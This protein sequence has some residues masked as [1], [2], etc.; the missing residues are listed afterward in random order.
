MPLDPSRQDFYISL[1][2]DTRGQIGDQAFERAWNKGK[3]MALQEAIEF[4][5]SLPNEQE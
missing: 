1:I 2:P 5:S 3:A 4:A